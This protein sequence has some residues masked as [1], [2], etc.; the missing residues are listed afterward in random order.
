MLR[1][2][3]I[4]LA[5]ASGCYLPGI[6]RQDH[7]GARRS[8]NFLQFSDYGDHR[9]APFAQEPSPAYRR[10]GELLGA[11][12]LTMVGGVLQSAEACAAFASECI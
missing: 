9:F 1:T 5:L 11:C 10:C 4:L 3:P 12:T 2:L 7:F 6:S 8:S